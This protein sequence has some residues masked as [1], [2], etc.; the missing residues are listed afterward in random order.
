MKTRLTSLLLSLVLLL[1]TVIATPSD[2]AFG[3]LELAKVAGSAAGI[4]GL[5]EGFAELQQKLEVAFPVGMSRGDTHGRLSEA[6]KQIDVPSGFRIAT[7]FYDSATYL[8]AD[9]AI[10]TGV[11]RLTIRFKF[12]KQNR[13]GPVLSV[14]SFE[15]SKDNCV[16]PEGT[17]GPSG[18]IRRDR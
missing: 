14:L 9:R 1:T 7:T 15:T 12:D 2:D 13:L 5:T 8:V 11:A 6:A 16:W 17:G 18:P 4:S 10:G 3:G